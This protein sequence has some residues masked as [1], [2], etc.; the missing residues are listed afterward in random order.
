MAVPEGERRPCKMDV[1]MH[2]LDL[3]TY[4]LQITRNEKIFLPEYKGCVTDDIVETAKNIYIDSWDANNIRVQKRGDSNWEERS[5]LQLRAAR[6]CNR[7]LA[8]IGI[9]KSSFH[10]KSKRVKYWVG[11]VLKIRGMIR[12][13]N[14]SDSERYAVKQRNPDNYSSR[15]SRDASYVTMHYTGNNKDTARA[16]ANY[17]GGAGRNASAHLFVDDTEIYQSVPLNSVAWHCGAQTYKHAYCRNANSIGIEMCCTAGNYKISEKTKQNA[18]YLCAYICKMLGISAGEVDK[19]VLRHWDVTGKN[20]PAQMAG[21]NNAEWVAFK[22]MVKSIL[23]GGGTGNS[24]SGGTQTKQMYRVRK[25][26]ADAAS[27][28][29]AFTSLE[30]A[31][32]CADENKGY[33]VFDSN[34]NKVYPASANTGTSCNY[35]VKITVDGLRYRDNPGTSGTKVLGYLKKNY[36][37]TVVEERTV[38][39]VKWGELKSGAGWFSLQSE[40]SVRC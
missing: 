27:Q 2:E 33:S 28:K 10:L 40:Y 7:L 25:T 39:G 8:L 30:N 23:N 13:W 9:A 38:N 3:V 16:N 35:V 19:Y 12:N 18:A 32:K 4:T 29:G 36:K 22:N 15:S 6:N 14:E 1:F 21:S 5:R 20:C 24:T 37:Y 34:G 26:W 31:K 11:K 17:F